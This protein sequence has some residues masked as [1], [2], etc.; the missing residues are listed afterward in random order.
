MCLPITISTAV[1][2]KKLEGPFYNDG[3]CIATGE[4]LKMK[5]D[6]DRNGN[7]RGRKLEE[8]SR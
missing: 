7:R 6:R 8:K 2:F 4:L 5:K 1:F 3:N